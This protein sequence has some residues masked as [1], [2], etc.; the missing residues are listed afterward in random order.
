MGSAAAAERLEVESLAGPEEAVASRLVAAAAAAA[1][2]YLFAE[3]L[4]GFAETWLLHFAA[5]TAE[6]LTAGSGS[7][8]VEVSHSAAA[9]GSGEQA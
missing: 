5:A 2:G 9:A 6:D 8:R 4:V 3:R 7:E 1:A